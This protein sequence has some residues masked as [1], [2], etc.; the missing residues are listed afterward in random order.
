MRPKPWKLISSRAKEYYKIFNI[1]TDRALSPRTKK[2]H[3]FYILESSDWVNVLPLTP[4]KEVVLIRQYRHGIRQVT[5]E[6]PG[7]IVEEGD[8]PEK[9]AR[10]ELFE[11]TGYRA[12]K[13]RFLGRVH[14]NPA[15]L[16]NWCHTF[17][18]EEACL[19]G[20]QAQ[21][22][23]EDIEV[24]LCPLEEI[25]GLI[26]EEKITHALVLVAFYL[27][28]SRRSSTLPG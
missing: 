14:P 5:L 9:A 17:L 3:D 24:V 10:R 26:R 8:S 23:K 25:P 27:F 22:E 7:G 20:D 2:E 15:F 28:F 16:D 12:A 18:A 6:I 4:A 19:A 21:D 13:M 1:R 11:E